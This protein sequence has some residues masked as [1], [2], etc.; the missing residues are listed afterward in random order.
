M[1]LSDRYQYVIL[2]ED[3]QMNTFIRESLKCAG[4]NARKIRTVKFPAGQG[5]GEQHVKM[6]FSEEV[7]RLQ[8]YNYLRCALVVCIDA[9]RNEYEERKRELVDSVKG[10]NI[11]W[12]PDDKMVMI[13]IPKRE[14]ETWIDFFGGNDPNEEMTFKHTGNPM[15]CKKEAKKMSLYCQGVIT[16]DDRK[17]PSLIQAKKEYER[18]CK[19]QLKE[20]R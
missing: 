14:I 20:T 18:V 4:I 13:W 19:L 2:C 8:S 5:C 3:S 10:V 1:K 6:H 15:P 11:G 12:K 7:E 9:D 17:L 16:L